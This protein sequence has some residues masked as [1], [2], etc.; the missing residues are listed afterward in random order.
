VRQTKLAVGQL[1]GAL[2]GVFIVTAGR[3]KCS[4]TACTKH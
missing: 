3:S 4:A 1:L 2:I